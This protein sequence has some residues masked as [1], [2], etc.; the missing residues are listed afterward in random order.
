MGLFL[1][2][3]AGPQPPEEVVY[4][5]FVYMVGTDDRVHILSGEFQGKSYPDV[6]AAKHAID[7]YWPFKKDPSDG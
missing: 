3:L 1:R 6:A 2:A 4:R 7:L 5:G